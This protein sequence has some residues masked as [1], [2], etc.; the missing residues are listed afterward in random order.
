MALE[1]TSEEMA[2]LLEKIMVDLAKADRGNQAAAQRVRTGTVI[3]SKLAVIYRKE[4]VE[5]EKKINASKE[6]KRG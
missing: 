3:L 6:R 2:E 1:D 4:S 5:E